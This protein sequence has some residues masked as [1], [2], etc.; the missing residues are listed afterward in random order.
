M[1]FKKQ[2]VNEKMQKMVKRNKWFELSDYVEGSKEQKVALAKALGMSD[3]NNSVEILL[4]LVDD[5]DEDVLY[6]TCESLRKVGTEHAT[7]DLLER[8]QKVP[9]EN[10][11]LRE[12]ISKT[13]Q[14]LH[15][16][17]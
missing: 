13:V 5:E 14:E 2:S 16:R 11:K 6:A 10:E 17:V 7:A 9:K 8:M 15:H 4:R 12:E 3:S 1:L